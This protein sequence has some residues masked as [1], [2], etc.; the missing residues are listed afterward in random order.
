MV[1][2]PDGHGPVLVGAFSPCRYGIKITY[3]KGIVKSFFGPVKKKFPRHSNNLLDRPKK[4]LA[5]GKKIALAP[6]K[7]A[8]RPGPDPG[9]MGR[10]AAGHGHGQE[11]YVADN[12][13]DVGKGRQPAVAWQPLVLGGRGVAGALAGRGQDAGRWRHGGRSPRGRGEA[14]IKKMKVDFSTWIE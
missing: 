6:R 3:Q 13:G 9:P 10:G 2:S 5:Q 8:S 4:S 1:P 14:G 12:T 11:T 7:T